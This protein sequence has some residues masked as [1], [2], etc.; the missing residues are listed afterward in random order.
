MPTILTHAVVPLAIGAGL[1]ARV[2][3]P[4]L[5]LAGAIGA[6]LPDL[7]V[8]GFRFGIEYG[9]DFGHRGFTHSLVFAALVALAATVAWRHLRAS[10]RCVFAFLFVSIASHGILDCFTD[11]G[12][13]VALLWPFWT[14]RFFAP[15]RP[16][17]VSPIGLSR[18]LSGNGMSVLLSELAWVWL[19]CGVLWASL[20]TARWVVGGTGHPGEHV[21]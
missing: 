3:P 16:I 17:A 11:G 20:W 12:R 10:A 9:S 6:M 2:I 19:P 4:R 21:P 7:D 5:L 1:G 8:A 18:F 13:G 14:E 15:F